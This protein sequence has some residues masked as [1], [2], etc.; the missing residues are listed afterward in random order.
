MKRIGLL[1]GMSWASSAEDYRRIMRG[2][3]D[4]GA[5]CILFGCTPVR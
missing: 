2:L 4:R 3:A 1:G 5:E